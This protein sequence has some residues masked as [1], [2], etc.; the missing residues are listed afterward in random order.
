KP[1]TVHDGSNQGVNQGV[2]YGDPDGPTPTVSTRH[3]DTATGNEGT[4][5][6]NV[7]RAGTARHAA[8]HRV[9]SGRRG[10]FYA[11]RQPLR[12]WESRS[13][14]RKT[15]RWETGAARAAGACA[16]R[17]RQSGHRGKSLADRCRPR[18][19]PGRNRGP[20]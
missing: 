15:P 20:D 17:T 10:P 16:R 14:T 3:G 13:A 9:V 5:A 1:A 7:D 6:E 19:E 11:T 4:A 12:A 18:A 8:R 2:R